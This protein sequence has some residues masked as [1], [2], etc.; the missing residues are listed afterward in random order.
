MTVD[1]ASALGQDL[2]GEGLPGGVGGPPALVGRPLLPSSFSRK[3]GRDRTPA[4]DGVVE[5]DG[6]ASARAERSSSDTGTAP[7]FAF[8]VREAAVA[9]WNDSRSFSVGARSSPQ[10]PGSMPGRRNAAPRSAAS[11]SASAATRAVP[12]IHKGTHEIARAL[13]QPHERRG[14]ELDA[15][16]THAWDHPGGKVERLGRRRVRVSHRPPPSRARPRPSGSR[17][18][19][20]SSRPELHRHPHPRA[21][22][23]QRRSVKRTSSVAGAEVSVRLP[24]PANARIEGSRLRMVTMAAPLSLSWLVTR[25]RR[26]PCRPRRGSAGTSACSSHRLVDADLRSPRPK[27]DSRSAATAMMRY[28]V[29]VSGSVTS[30]SRGRRVRRHRPEPERQHAEVLAEACRPRVAPAAAAVGLALRREHAAADDA[31][32]DVLV[33]DLQRLLHVDRP[34]HVGRAI[35]GEGQHAVVHR[36]QRD[37]AT[38]RGGRRHRLTSRHARLVAGRYSSWLAGTATCNRFEASS[39][40]QL[41]VARAGRPACPGR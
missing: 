29:S 23:G 12:R 25:R 17:L 28:V 30:L 2:H 6:R 3:V 22:A 32:A 26:T 40:L 37:L 34:Q 14:R 5:V 16:A 27:R 21:A 15:Q 39:T 11:M 36:P 33:H 31:L 24:S 19:N 38:A 9:H 13:A 35:G 1:V 4:W 10:L 18:S 8:P 7:A 41:R 20:A